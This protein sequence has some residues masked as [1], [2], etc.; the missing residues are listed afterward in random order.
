MIKISFYFVKL[1]L[2]LNYTLL[3]YLA[4][5]NPFFAQ[6]HVKAKKRLTQKKKNYSETVK[7]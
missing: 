7:C 6:E 2:P 4:L 3:H 5:P 1:L